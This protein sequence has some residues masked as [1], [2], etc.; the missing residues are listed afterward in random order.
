MGALDP[1][2]LDRVVVDVIQVPFQVGPIA[3]DMFPEPPLPDAPATIMATRFADRALP[4]AGGDP[5][6]REGFLDARPSRGKIRIALRQR[7]DRVQVIRK[8]DQ[9]VQLER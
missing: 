9:R 3:D 8:Q 7:S 2:V 1:P 5:C 4:S 6:A